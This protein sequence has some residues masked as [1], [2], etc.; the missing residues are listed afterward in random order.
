MTDLSMES[1]FVMGNGSAVNYHIG[2][3]QE[4]S[5]P[6]ITSTKIFV[7]LNVVQPKKSNLINNLNQQLKPNPKIFCPPNFVSTNITELNQLT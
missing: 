4:L 1:L 5:Q 6:N 3:E 2:K 7:Q